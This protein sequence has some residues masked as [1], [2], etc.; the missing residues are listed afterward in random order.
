ME[1][2]IHL[3]CAKIYAVWVSLPKL[4]CKW[5]PVRIWLALILWTERLAASS[6]GWGPGDQDIWK[7]RSKLCEKWCPLPFLGVYEKKKEKNR[8]TSNGRV[9]LGAAV[10]K[11]YILTYHLEHPIIGDLRSEPYEVGF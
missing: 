8:R 9:P 10:G 3:S 4:Q 6:D 1:E 5:M 11:G 2:I 7:K